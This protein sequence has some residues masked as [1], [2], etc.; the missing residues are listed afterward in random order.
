MYCIYAIIFMYRYFCGFGL[1]AE[2]CEGL[3]SKKNYV[4]ITINRHKLKWKFL[5]D[6]TCEIH[7]NKTTWKYLTTHTVYEIL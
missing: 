2:I 6:P 1:R 3:I 5:Q 7:E 4:F